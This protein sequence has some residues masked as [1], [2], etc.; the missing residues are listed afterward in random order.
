MGW[1]ISLCFIFI[2]LA[3]AGGLYYSTIILCNNEIAAK[4]EKKKEIAERK[5]ARMKEAAEKAAK[6]KADREILI[7]K[8]GEPDKEITIEECDITKEIIAF[9]KDQRLVLM[10]E[11]LPFCDVLGCSLD[12][13]PRIRRGNITYES[14]TKTNN[15]NM[16]GR[17]VV[18][19]VLAGGAGAVIGGSTANK[20]TQTIATQGDDFTI[21]DY[22]VI[23]N[24]NSLKNPIVRIA[25][26]RDG[27]T[28]NEIV[29]LLNV[30]MHAK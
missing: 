20:N 24:I 13:T 23:I 5:A 18:G 16:L 21:H 9:G 22:T 25:L 3:V 26:G 11:D 29:G 15:G 14:K 2:T 27:K 4:E 10:G 1:G 30:I 8:Y 6:Y 17:A 28:A 19:G 12:D 7:N